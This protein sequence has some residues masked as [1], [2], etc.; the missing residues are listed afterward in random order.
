MSKPTASSNDPAL[1]S[2]I[3]FIEQ[4]ASCA[5]LDYIKHLR[6][7]HDHEIVTNLLPECN[8]G[9]DILDTLQWNILE[10]SAD[11][12]LHTALCELTEMEKKLL[13]LSILEDRPME[14][15]AEL[16]HFSLSRAYQLRRNALGKLRNALQGGK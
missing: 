12:A 16:L 5:R 11:L 15:I 9:A 1:G 2:F 6:P 8:G 7:F 10:I 13:A 4:V 14:E 3:R